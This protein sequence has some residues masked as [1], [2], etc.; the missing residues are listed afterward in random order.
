MPCTSYTANV[1]GTYVHRFSGEETAGTG[2]FRV[3]AVHPIAAEIAA[4]QCFVADGS[5]RNLACA[6]PPTVALTPT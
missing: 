4:A 1:T 6:G 2:R 3:T 5:R